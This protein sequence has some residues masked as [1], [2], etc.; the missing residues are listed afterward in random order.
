MAAQ[1]AISRKRPRK[2]AVQRKLLE[3]DEVGIDSSCPVETVLPVAA[4]LVNHNPADVRLLQKFPLNSRHEIVCKGIRSARASLSVK[5]A[6]IILA[7]RAS[8]LGA[9]VQRHLLPA[10]RID[11]YLTAEEQLRVPKSNLTDADVLEVEL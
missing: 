8:H 10:G 2:K 9:H 5:N 11:S 1:I 6:N 3:Q 4:L 7:E